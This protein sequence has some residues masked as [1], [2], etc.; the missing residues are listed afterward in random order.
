M[1]KKVLENAGKAALGLAL[2]TSILSFNV[3]AQENA[4]TS[5][6]TNE[7][8][9]KAPTEKEELEGKVG[10]STKNP[11]EFIANLSELINKYP[12]SFHI[13]S[14]LYSFDRT[15]KDVKDAGEARNLVNRLIK[16]TEPAAA[17][18]RGEIYRRGA[19]TLFNR[20]LYED[21]AKLAQQAIDLF[22]ETA[23]LDFER[24]KHD[25]SMTEYAARNPQFKPRAFDTERTRG[26][27]VGTKSDVYYLL[28]KI[29]REEGQFD[30]AEKAFRTSFAVKKNRNAALG[31][32]R[33]AEKNGKDAEA[34]D[35]AATAVLTAG[36]PDTSATDYF[37]ALYA[38]RHQGKTEGAEKYLDDFYKK[39]YRNP[40]KSEK[41]KK[42]DKRSDRTVLVE[43]VTGA[44]CI[45]CIPFDYTFENALHDFSRKDVAIIAFHWHAPTMDPLGNHSSDS[46][47][48][49]Y[50]VSGAPTTFIDGKKFEKDGDYNGADGEQS[51]IQPI[52]DDVYKTLKTNLEI[53]ADADLQLKARRNGQNI[54]V[55]V[56]ADKFKNVSDDVT[57][58]IALAEN[59][60]TY[61]GENGL[62]FHFMVA[63]A[64]AGDE[65]KR[66]YG[67]KVDSTKP[68]KFEYVFDVDG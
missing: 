56:D 49:Y 51:E 10:K 6:K 45:P 36:R 53:P 54:V 23:Y 5:S 50:G 14:Y 48:K 59:E 13:Q 46:R 8:A 25:A 33:A 61:S 9:K 32:A 44:G 4:S 40:V 47:V 27:Y 63:R 11:P 41:Y 1:I 37:Y 64:L 17:P 22:D 60:A 3:I 2:L 15:L 19:D 52:A 68:N 35:Y 12:L 31:I 62:R 7:A 57:L 34:L 26:S 39:T 66:I 55:T 30:P 16:N 20:G 38:K 28:G 21:A 43:F 58:H 29:F 65:E 42:T 24:K 18:L 67:F